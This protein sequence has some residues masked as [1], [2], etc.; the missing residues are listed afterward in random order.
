MKIRPAGA[1]LFHAD[2]R[3]D[4]TKLIVGFRNFTIAPKI[5]SQIVFKIQDGLLF[6]CSGH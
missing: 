1:E 5:G 6:W 4:L 2:R 3:T